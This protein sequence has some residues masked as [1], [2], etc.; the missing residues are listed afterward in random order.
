MAAG[1][2]TEQPTQRRL[3]EARRKGQVAKSVEVPSALTLLAAIVMLT[4]IG[5]TIFNNIQAEVISTLQFQTL[6]DHFSI[7]ATQHIAL[8]G[9]YILGLSVGPLLAAVA[10]MG[11]VGNLAQTGV[12]FT[13]SA[14]KPDIKRINPVQG[15]KRLFS[16]R[17]LAEFIKNMLKLTAVGAVSIFT[18]MGQ[19]HNIL[20]LSGADPGTLLAFMAKLV[21]SIGYRVSM[22]LLLIAAAD[23]FFQ[24]RN[25]K[26]ELRMT[27][28][29]VKQEMK[30]SEMNFRVRGQI[31]QEAMNSARTRML[32]E[33]PT[34]DVVITNPT[35]FACA[36][37]YKEGEDA[38]PRL[39]A[40]GQD[41]IALKI[42]EVA[43]ENKI[44]IIEN[45]PIARTLYSKVE[46]GQEIPES[47]FAAV[48]EVIALV[49]RMQ[50]H[51]RNY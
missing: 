34:A 18:V 47:L 4:A 23:L 45:P 40:K 5:Q 46:V 29:E 48:A 3:E 32:S 38:A 27:K 44:P 11:I 13:P 28:E 22:L 35:H 1:D 31:R 51:K 24:R 43:A 25:H 39:I 8:H 30:Q 14:L 9:V 2:K 49:W 37:S 20:L 26:R 33:V 19:W 36:L 10:L 41:L 42:R 16:R 6:P 50:R 7:L 17:T 15:V 12:A 21:I